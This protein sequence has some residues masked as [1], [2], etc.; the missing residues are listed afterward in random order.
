MRRREDNIKMGLKGTGYND[1]ELDSTDAL[2]RS[3]ERGNKPL[4]SM[5]RGGGGC[6]NSC[7]NINFSGLLLFHGVSE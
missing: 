6:F 3:F 2:V 1:V 5:E 7:A 4:G